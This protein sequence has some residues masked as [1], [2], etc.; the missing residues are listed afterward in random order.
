MKEVI[1][2]KF[3]TTLDVEDYTEEADRENQ[4]LAW[5]NIGFGVAPHETSEDK[6]YVYGT[7]NENTIMNALVRVKDSIKEAIVAGDFARVLRPIDLIE[8]IFKFDSKYETN[9]SN[10]FKEDYALLNEYFE[11]QEEEIIM[12]FENNQPTENNEEASA[13]IQVAENK[14]EQ[15]NINETVPEVSKNQESEPANEE[16][17]EEEINEP[18]KKEL[19][20]VEENE[21]KENEIK[22]EEIKEEENKEGLNIKVEV[23]NSSDLKIEDIIEIGPKGVSNK[24]MIPAMKT[25][26]EEKSKE[27]LALLKFKYPAVY[28]STIKYIGHKR[29]LEL[30]KL[31][32][33]MEA[34]Q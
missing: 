30:K 17:K 5:K 21:I 11:N 18:I 2:E 28:E 8:V 15:V 1:N 12:S 24:Q 27:K 20:K 13:N 16:I 14:E 32:E 23:V 33:E 6:F 22:E 9:F 3:R 4:M 7:M 31:E 34:A 29:A 26:V 10:Q 25:A 19:D